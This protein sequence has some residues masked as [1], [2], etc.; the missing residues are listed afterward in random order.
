MERSMVVW[1]MVYM[2]V[3]EEGGVELLHWNIIV[4]RK[5]PLQ[6]A[7]RHVYLVFTLSYEFLMSFEMV[8]ESCHCILYYTSLVVF[9]FYTLPSFNYFVVLNAI[10]RLGLF[11]SLPYYSNIIKFYSVHMNYSK[12]I[13]IPCSNSFPRMSII[14]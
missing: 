7:R 14:I 4:Q 9:S 6:Q 12:A 13:T 2:S 1:Y 8:Y 10:I 3:C 5:G 11:L